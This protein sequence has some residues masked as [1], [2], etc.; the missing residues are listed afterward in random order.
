[1]GSEVCVEEWGV[2]VWGLEFEVEGSA[3]R[4]W[5]LGFEVLEFGV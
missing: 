1:L 3:F 4:V 2:E 5:G